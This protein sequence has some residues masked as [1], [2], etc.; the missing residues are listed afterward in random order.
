M[1]FLMKFEV[2]FADHKKVLACLGKIS[3]LLLPLLGGILFL[4]IVFVL[5]DVFV[6]VKGRDS[7]FDN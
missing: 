6:C 3:N 1:A 2:R 7:N 5:S 4:P